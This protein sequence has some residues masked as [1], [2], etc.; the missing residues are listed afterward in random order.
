LDKANSSGVRL[1]IV[2]R[3]ATLSFD[4]APA[5]RRTAPATKAQISSV[6][7]GP[8][9]DPKWYWVPNLLP[10]WRATADEDEHYCFAVAL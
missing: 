4:A 2:E 10:K 6:A 8:A 7:I 3:Q 5:V 9:F 1:A